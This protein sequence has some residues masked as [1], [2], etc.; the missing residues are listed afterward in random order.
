MNRHTMYLRP[1]M[2]KMIKFYI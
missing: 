1:D 2:V